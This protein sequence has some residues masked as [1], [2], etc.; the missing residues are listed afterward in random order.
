MHSKLNSATHSK[1]NAAI[2]SKLNA[3]I[4]SK[5][6]S[7]IHSK[8]KPTMHSA[9][10][11]GVTGENVGRPCR[12]QIGALAVTL[13]ELFTLEFPPVNA[14]VFSLRYI[15]ANLSVVIRGLGLG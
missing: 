10:I 3:A 15:G 11:L 1:L 12:G 4:H 14:P 7:A 5:L 6:N 8:L 2:H 13:W 9:K